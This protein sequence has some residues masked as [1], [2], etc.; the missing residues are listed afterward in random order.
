MTMQQPKPAQEQKDSPRAAIFGEILLRV[1]EWRKTHG[2]V[3]SRQGKR[4]YGRSE[5]RKER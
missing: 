5:Q 4:R 1:F 2:K 3:E